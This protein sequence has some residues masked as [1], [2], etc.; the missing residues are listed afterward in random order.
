MQFYINVVCNNN[1]WMFVQFGLDIGYDVVN[2]ML[3]FFVMIGLLDVLEQEKVLFK[4]ILYFLNLWD[5]EVL[6]VIVGSFQG[7]G[8]LGKIQFGVVWWFNDIKDGMFVQMR[9][10]VNVGLL[11]CF[12][13]MFMDLCSF[14]FYIRY[15]YFCCLVCNLIGEWV[16]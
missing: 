8:I 10:L 2:D 5:N 9:V 14:F 6:V 13:G 1:S 3:F 11:S 4:I 16:E 15:E 12:V 7:G